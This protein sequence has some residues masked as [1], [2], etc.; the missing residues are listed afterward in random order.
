LKSGHPTCQASVLPLQPYSQPLFA[1]SV[2]QIAS[3]IFAWGSPQTVILLPMV[4]YIA[5]T[6][7]VHLHTWLINWDRGLTNFFP[8]LASNCSPIDSA[9]WDYSHSTLPSEVTFKCLWCLTTSLYS[10]L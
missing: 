5:G 10:P 2:F 1:L 7:G 6:T 4:Y 9:S 8:G 3:C